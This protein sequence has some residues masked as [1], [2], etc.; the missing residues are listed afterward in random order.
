MSP[1]H[2][3]REAGSTETGNAS[4]AENAQAARARYEMEISGW[5]QKHKLY[6][7]DANGAEGRAVVRMR[8]DRSG[9]V[10]YYGIEEA[11]GNAVLDAAAID[12]IRR[13]NPMPVVP[14]DYP[15][16]SLVE[17]LIPISFKVPR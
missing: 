14:S 16:G 12:M 7:P 11:S 4:A 17:F 9:N 3:I 2:F 1:Q 13:A 10:R 5:I 8:I 15:A 6:P